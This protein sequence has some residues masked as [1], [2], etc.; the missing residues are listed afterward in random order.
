MLPGFRFL[1]AAI[2]LSVS[3]LVFGLGAAALLRAA[4]EEVASNP[5]WRATREVRF[6]P[7][8]QTDHRTLAMLRI[9]PQADATKMTDAPVGMNLTVAS[10]APAA[11][12]PPAPEGEEP[13]VATTTSSIESTNAEGV[14]APPAEAPSS[15]DA[16]P[17][18]ATTVAAT[19]DRPALAAE[20]KAAA[21]EDASPHEDVPAPAVVEATPPEQLHTP[22]A[23]AAE[24]AAPA[25]TLA[26]QGDQSATVE[27]T[28]KVVAKPEHSATKSHLRVQRA[29]APRKTARARPALQQ[30]TAV[31]PPVFPLFEAQQPPS[32][33]TQVRSQK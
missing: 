4:H 30:A 21:M 23:P 25:T 31:Q 13:P 12:E 15:G 18:A 22:P 11:V 10:A 7:A 32:P 9:E 28:A 19:T 29:K 27:K 6:A 33:A 2:L 8:E 1:L 16:A 26:S 3:I 24:T 14:E 20:T 17:V 5:S